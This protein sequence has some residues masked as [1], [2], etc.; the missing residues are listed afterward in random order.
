M[1]LKYYPYGS[2]SWKFDP[3]RYR[4]RYYK[5]TIENCELM[6]LV[7]QQGLPIYMFLNDA[8]RYYAKEKFGLEVKKIEESKE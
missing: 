6:N 3:A 2:S 4:I 7:R 8:I 5:I 1:D